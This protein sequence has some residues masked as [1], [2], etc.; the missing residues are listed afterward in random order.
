MKFVFVLKRTS[1][2]EPIMKTCSRRYLPLL[3][4]ALLPLLLCS[5]TAVGTYLGY[6]IDQ[7]NTRMIQANSLNADTIPAGR[8]VIVKCTDGK[9]VTGTFAGVQPLPAEKYYE[10]YSAAR[11]ALDSTVRLPALDDTLIVFQLSGSCFE[12]IFNGFGPQALVA[13]D[14]WSTISRRCPLSS[15]SQLQAR[16]GKPYDLERIRAL[17]NAQ[18]L[19]IDAGVIVQT[20]TVTL[21]IPLNEVKAITALPKRTHWWI[22]GAVVGCI[23]DAVIVAQIIEKSIRDSLPNWGPSRSR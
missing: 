14:G 9:V 10:N 4:T 8:T 17:M 2:K 7:R 21:Q 22:A 12:W 19:P 13:N 20:K 3:L 18:Q 23:A 15:I 11:T 1:V 5:C 6:R 16:N